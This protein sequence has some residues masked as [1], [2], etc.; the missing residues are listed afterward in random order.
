MQNN[1]EFIS[2]LEQLSRRAARLRSLAKQKVVNAE[3]GTLWMSSLDIMG[4]LLNV[5]Y[6]LVDDQ[7]QAQ[8]HSQFASFGDSDDDDDTGEILMQCPNCH[9]IVNISFGAVE[10]AAAT[11]PHCGT[12][13][14]LTNPT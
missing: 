13:V 3:D 14:L 8:L 6:K 2:R 7:Q 9:D 11:C 10:E 1:P 5:V 4:E 12:T